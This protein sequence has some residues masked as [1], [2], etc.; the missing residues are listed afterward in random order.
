MY[1][2]RVVC[3]GE[4]GIEFL[5]KSMPTDAMASFLDLEDAK[6]FASQIQCFMDGV[7]PEVKK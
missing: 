7:D 4:L 1:I 5:R 6:E 3:P 2:V